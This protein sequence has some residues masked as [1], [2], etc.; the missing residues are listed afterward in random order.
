M[1][2]LYDLIGARR[3]DDAESLKK[4]Y[5]K[6]VKATHPDYHADD[7]EAVRQ[8]MQITAAYDILRDAEQRMA[9]DWTLDRC[10]AP[11]NATLK[12]TAAPRR[13]FFVSS[14]SVIAAVT[15]MLSGAF[16]LFARVSE[17]SIQDV[18]GRRA[19]HATAAVQPAVPQMPIMA[20]GPSV[21]TST[22]QDRSTSEETKDQTASQETK[23][24][25]A[26]QETKD[27]TASTGTQST[28]PSEETKDRPASQETAQARRAIYVAKRD[29]DVDLINRSSAPEK[30]NGVP[31]S[32]SYGPWLAKRHRG[33]DIRTDAR[34]RGPAF[35]E[36]LPPANKPAPKIG[37]KSGDTLVESKPDSFTLGPLCLSINS[38]AC[39][40]AGNEQR[41]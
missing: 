14:M 22:A 24:E 7:P 3:D 8:F 38:T 21:A 13:R 2:T 16:L 4:A 28:A 15:L 6:A 5:R 25:T 1:K 19:P 18:V 11:P 34:T 37:S 36:T 35:A 31:S 20:A 27:E 39:P 10:R 32:E 33:S 30:R 9:Y 23:D 17:F 29:V 12:H 40:L 26:S 41:R